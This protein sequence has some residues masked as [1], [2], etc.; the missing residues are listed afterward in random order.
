MWEGGKDGWREAGGGSGGFSLPGILAGFVSRGE[1]TRF[2]F[3]GLEQGIKRV[4][5]RA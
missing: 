1:L 5:E 4:T 3:A 2:S